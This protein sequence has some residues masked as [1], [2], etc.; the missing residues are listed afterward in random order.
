MEKKILLRSA[1]IA[2]IILLALILAYV[3]F[4]QKASAPATTDALQKE[5]IKATVTDFEERPVNNPPL[6]ITECEYKD[7]TVYYVPPH[8]CDIP[9]IVY[10]LQGAEVCAPTGGLT[11]N[12]DGKCADFF[13]AKKDCRTIWQDSRKYSG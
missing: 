11:G 3:V 4:T 12:G 8:C 1:L 7:Q 5:W 13:D 9:G 2:S 10:D 6:S